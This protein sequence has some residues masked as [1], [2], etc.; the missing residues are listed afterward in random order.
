MAENRFKE[1]KTAEPEKL[2]PE[3]E[4]YLKKNKPSS[5]F[6]SSLL[7]SDLLPKDKVLSAL[8]YFLFLVFLGFVYITNR[9]KS[10]GKIR[11]I[12]LWTQQNQ[13]LKWEYISLEAKWMLATKQSEIAQKA[14][15]LGLKESTSP[16]FIIRVE[17]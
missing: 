14:L 12:T 11:Q 17:K 6:I 8:P 16:P 13:E 15:P 7:S 3:E 5:N 9:Y 1:S 2:L 10:E 4:P